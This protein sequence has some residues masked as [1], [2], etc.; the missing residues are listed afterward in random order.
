[1][2]TATASLITVSAPQGNESYP[3]R[4]LRF[5]Q[6]DVFARLVDFMRNQPIPLGLDSIETDPDLR[7]PLVAALDIDFATPADVDFF[8]A[9]LG[10]KSM[11]GTGLVK[12]FISEDGCVQI[13]TYQSHGLYVHVIDGDAVIVCVATHPGAVMPHWTET[14][15]RCGVSTEVLV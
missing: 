2:T 11:P 1:M 7:S 6:S 3:Q 15:E 5:A 4:R 8:L 12:T 9:T 14:F 13:D 10:D